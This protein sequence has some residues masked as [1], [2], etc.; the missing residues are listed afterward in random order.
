MVPGDIVV[1]EGG[2]H[3]PADVRLVS[4]ADF[5][6]DESPLTGESVPV[7]KDAAASLP[8]DTTLADRSTMA[9]M[10]TMAVRGRATA[11]AVSTGV[12]TEIGRIGKLIGGIAAGLSPLEKRMARFSHG[13]LIACLGI[14]AAFFA[15][16]F[17]LGDY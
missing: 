7:D 14:A 9:Y 3:V 11:V 17:A 6:T 13:I 2:D 5:R 12:G 10:G 1:L 4:A 16:A 15:L 8:P